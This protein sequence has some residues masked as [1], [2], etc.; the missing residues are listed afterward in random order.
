MTK[1][2][3]IIFGNCQGH[4]IKKYLEFSDFY[5]IYDVKSYSNWELLSNHELC[6][7]VQEIQSADLVI[8]QP[9]TDIHN[10]YSTNKKNPTSFFNLL[11]E[12]CNTI[13][14]PRIHNNA[15]FPIFHKNKQHSDIYGRFTNQ[16]SN[17][18]SLIYL[19][20]NNLVDYDFTNRM[21]ENYAISKQKEEKCD[22]RII[23]YILQNIH[24][25][26]MFLT[27]DHPTSCVLNEITKQICDIA[28]ANYNFDK[29]DSMDENWI[30]LPDSVYSRP[31][32]QYPIS[33]YAIHHFGFEYVK[34]ED[35]DADLFYKN[36][37]LEKFFQK[38]T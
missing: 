31:T 30:G 28:G 12:S 6:I 17:E 9:L 19:Y 33:R 22:V 10:C 18:E 16:V 5:E 29:V 8:Y 25:R 23:D 36:I 13:S 21:Q 35:P 15:I 4:A 26:K 2:S 38:Q 11:Q 24:K 7:P 32:N 34:E 1:K 3:C 14:F 37:T 20:E 27:Q